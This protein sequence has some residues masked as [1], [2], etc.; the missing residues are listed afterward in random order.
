MLRAGAPGAGGRPAAARQG[1]RRSAAAVPGAA[2]RGETPTPPSAHPGLGPALTAPGGHGAG[3]AP[4]PWMGEDADGRE[5]AARPG[6][7]PQSWAAAAAARRR[8]ARTDSPYLSTGPPAPSDAH[9]R[10]PEL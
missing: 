7:S 9:S 1:P 3:R 5:E 8:R 10:C 6:K 2:A 4:R